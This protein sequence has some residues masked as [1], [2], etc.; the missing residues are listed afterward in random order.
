MDDFRDSIANALRSRPGTRPQFFN[1]A[2]ESSRSEMR[3]LL[4][5]SVIGVSDDYREQQRELFAIRNPALAHLREF[6]AQFDAYYEDLGNAA[7]G[8]RWV[9]FPWSGAL[10]HILDE[11]DFFTVRTARNRNLITEDEQRKFYGAHVGLAGLSVG[12][13]VAFALALGGGAKRM[14]LADMDTLSLSNTNR[15]LSSVTELGEHKVNMAARRIYEINPYAEVETMPE[16]LTEKNI[17]NFFEGLDIVVDEVDNLAVKYLLRREAKRRR[18]PIVMAADNGDGVVI[19]IERYDLDHDLPFFHGRLGD[20]G[21]EELK[22]MD[23]INIGRTITRHIGAENVTPRMQ[24]SLLEIGKSLVSWPQLGGAA[25]LA[26]AAVAYCVRRIV[27][28]EPLESNRALVSFDE[29]LIPGYDAPSARDKRAEE[30]HA[31]AKRF[32]ISV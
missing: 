28:G 7:E 16:G 4:T 13:S 3:A 12:S 14:R 19:D 21:Y 30:G 31:F 18:I 25:M 29:M 24:E 15:V 23:K 5:D 11:G 26:G 32:G 10:S 22:K 6:D 2:V 17:G 27:S 1:V 8:G 20:L 9:Y